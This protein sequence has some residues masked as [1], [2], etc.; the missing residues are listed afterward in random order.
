MQKNKN[1]KNVKELKIRMKCKL[2]RLAVWYIG[3]CNK[4][5]DKP[6]KE[7]KTLDRLTY[8]NGDKA[9]LFYGGDAEW[10][11]FSR[12]DVLENAIQKLE[13]YENEECK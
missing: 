11:N 10:Q 13:K 12:Y 2:Y 7:I 3:K 9:Y 5:W 4:K 6:T 8:R 1:L